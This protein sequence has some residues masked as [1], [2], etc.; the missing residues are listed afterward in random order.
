MRPQVT[1][2]FFGIPRERAG[3]ASCCAQGETLGEVL[4]SLAQ[5]FPKLA[6]ECLAAGAPAAGYLVAINAQGFTRNPDYILTNG[7]TVQLLAADMGG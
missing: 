5:A 1:V 4:E 2:E 3:V 6:Q 7:D